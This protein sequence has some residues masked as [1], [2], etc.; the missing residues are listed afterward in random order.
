MVYISLYFQIDTDAIYTS[1]DSKQ[2]TYCYKEERHTHNVSIIRII[3]MVVMVWMNKM[4]HVNKSIADLTAHGF[5][6]PMK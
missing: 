6:A 1:Y 3:Y 5:M 2:S 4:S